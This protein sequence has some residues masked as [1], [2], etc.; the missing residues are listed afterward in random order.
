MPEFLR[1]T[2]Y[3]K[4]Q[5]QGSIRAFLPKGTD[6]PVLTSDNKKLKSWRQEFALAALAA[7]N[8][9]GQRM[10]PKMTPVEL[11][12]T[13]YLERPE[14]LAKRHLQ[15]MKK[16]DWDKLARAIGDSMSGVVYRDDNQVWH[17][18]IRKL[19]GLPERTEVVVLTDGL[20][21]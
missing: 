15:H 8:E 17:A 5:P 13:F 16:P 20:L 11:L 1:F 3:G 19:Y 21:P 4:A 6:R 18:D 7:M 14:H 9:G 12:V 2:V 10:L